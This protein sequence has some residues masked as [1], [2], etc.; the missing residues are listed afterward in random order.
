MSI[1]LCPDVHCS[2]FLSVSIWQ[3]ELCFLSSLESTQLLEEGSFN[4]KGHV[5]P[6]LSP[7]I[8]RMGDRRE[9][10]FHVLAS[11][12]SLDQTLCTLVPGWM[13]AQIELWCSLQ[14]LLWE[15]TPARSQRL[16][17]SPAKTHL[18]GLEGIP[19]AARGGS[20]TTRLWA[21][22]CFRIMR[23]CYCWPLQLSFT[24]GKPEST[25]PFFLTDKH[26][27]HFKG[28]IWYKCY[29][30]LRQECV[31]PVQPSCPGNH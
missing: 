18:R 21:H 7:N 28:Q 22:E 27:T 13:D 24:K 6:L 1:L 20:G 12:G 14:E 4:P 11:H 31:C 17:I 23:R 10:H 2:P 9:G 29:L 5:L 19:T 3:G 26:V 30:V 15:E 8:C 16:C 25:V